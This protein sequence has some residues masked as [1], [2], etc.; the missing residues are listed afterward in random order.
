MRFWTFVTA[1]TAVLGTLA[2]AH[3]QTFDFLNAAPGA[4]TAYNSSTVPTINTATPGSITDAPSAGFSYGRSTDAA[5]AFSSSPLFSTGDAWRFQFD[6]VLGNNT[7]FRIEFSNPTRTSALV[8]AMQNANATG[9]DF[10]QVDSL[11]TPGPNSLFS[12]NLGGAAGGTQ[13]VF[14]NVDITV[15]SG[16]T[17]L[18]SGLLSD[19]TGVVWNTPF[20]MDL[21]NTAP[22]LYAAVNVSTSGSA[23]GINALSWTFTPVPEPGTLTLVALGLAGLGLRRW[24]AARKL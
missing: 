10:L 22:T 1:T 9:A 7:T 21:G 19:S 8:F 23:T 6:G 24:R 16:T 13:R 3:A 5:G 11:G 20:T 14:G 17:A 12:G 15:Q 4:W 2:G 18:V